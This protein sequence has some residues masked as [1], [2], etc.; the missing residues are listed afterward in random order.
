MSAANT[1]KNAMSQP[2]NTWAGAMA[3]IRRRGASSRAGRRSVM[4]G[5]LSSMQTTTSRKSS[6]TPTRAASES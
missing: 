2:A 3:R 6:M 1:K 5:V 4:L